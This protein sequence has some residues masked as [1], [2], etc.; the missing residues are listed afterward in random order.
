MQK[1]EQRLADGRYLLLYSFPKAPLKEKRK[2]K[3]VN[4][5]AKERDPHV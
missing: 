2:T 5:L 4:K 1:S 3:M